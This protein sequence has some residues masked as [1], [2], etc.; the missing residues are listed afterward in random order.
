VQTYSEEVRS[1]KFPAEEHTYP[2]DAAEEAAFL[3][4]VAGR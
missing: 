1:R 3:A 2:M 4:A